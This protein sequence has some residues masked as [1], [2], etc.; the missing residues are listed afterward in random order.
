LI[1][2]FASTVTCFLNRPLIVLPARNKAKTLRAGKE[3]GT[4]APLFDRRVT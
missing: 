1:H 3:S 2:A 4:A